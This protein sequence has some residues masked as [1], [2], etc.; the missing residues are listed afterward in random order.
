M[1]RVYEYS[2]SSGIAKAEQAEDQAHYRLR[3]LATGRLVIDQDINYN[4]VQL[5]TLGLSPHIIAR[6]LDKLSDKQCEPAKKDLESFDT[7]LNLT[8][9]NFTEGTPQTY[10]E[11]DLRSRFS[12]V[13]TSPSLDMR[14]RANSCVQ[15]QHVATE[16]YLSYESKSTFKKDKALKN[17]VGV[18]GFNEED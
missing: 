18:S 6:N 5:K 15:I 14:I 13:S 1:G 8:V 17:N 10:R 12:I 2:V 3:H 16:M 11:L 9:E 7:D 4:G